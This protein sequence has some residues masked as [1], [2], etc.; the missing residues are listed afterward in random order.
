[1]TTAAV[2]ATTPT[3]GVKTNP[4]ASP[5]VKEGLVYMIGIDALAVLLQL[6]NNLVVIVS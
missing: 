1:M 2:M 3:I 6:R 4:T 5:T